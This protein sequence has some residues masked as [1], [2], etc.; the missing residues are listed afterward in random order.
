MTK[1]NKTNTRYKLTKTRN[2]L[3]KPEPEPKTPTYKLPYGEIKQ[4][5]NNPENSKNRNGI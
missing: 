3:K 5:K 1:K 2:I 4:K